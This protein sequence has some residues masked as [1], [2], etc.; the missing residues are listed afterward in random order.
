MYVWTVP[1]SFFKTIL[2]K[3]TLSECFITFLLF[4]NPHLFFSGS[5]SQLFFILKL[6]LFLWLVKKSWEESLDVVRISFP[7]LMVLAFDSCLV[8]AQKGQN[9]VSVSLGQVRHQA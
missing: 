4:L 3:L 7:V 6:A 5:I 9:E 8:K 2:D 1:L